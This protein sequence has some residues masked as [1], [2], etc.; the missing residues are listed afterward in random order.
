MIVV[1]FFVGGLAGMSGL[2]AASALIK[3]DWDLARADMWAAGI[4]ALISLVLLTWDLGRPL[5]FIYM[6]QVFEY[7]SPMSLG[8]CVLTG[9]GAFAVPGLAFTESYWSPTGKGRKG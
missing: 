5:R 1:Y 9:F 6:L 7:Q 8:S 3:S 2:I 4:G